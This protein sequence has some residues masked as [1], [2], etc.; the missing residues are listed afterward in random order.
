[1][2]P[3]NRNG[4]KPPGS[5]GKLPLASR[6][7]VARRL[8]SF[9]ESR[10]ITQAQFER[11]LNLSHATV[12]NWFNL[13]NPKTPDATSLLR[14]AERYNLSLDWILAGV[15]APLRQTAVDPADVAEAFRAAVIAEL[16]SRCQA[17]DAE[18]DTWV[19]KGEALLRVDVEKYADVVE[20]WRWA[21]EHLA[22]RVEQPPRHPEPGGA[23][24]STRGSVTP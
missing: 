17:T 24:S 19:P 18:I 11:E 9:L 7:S 6:Q 22:P 4:K 20:S 15:G 13:K 12:A 5:Y 2:P 8:T 14:M 3:K 23:T 16:R 1:M 21:L 10:G